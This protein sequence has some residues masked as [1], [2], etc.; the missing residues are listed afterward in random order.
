METVSVYRPF[1][2]PVP[3]LGPS[4]VGRGLGRWYGG[5][6][7]MGKESTT[8]EEERLLP[9]KVKTHSL[10]I[11]TRFCFRR[12]SVIESYV[13]RRSTVLEDSCRSPFPSVSTVVVEVGRHSFGFC[14]HRPHK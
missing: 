4:D 3:H 10:P 2:I 14:L 5:E 11:R 6:G 8:T 7:W 1:T 12:V 13:V 9:R